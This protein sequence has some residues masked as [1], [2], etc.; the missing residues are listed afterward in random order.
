M[1][2][3]LLLALVPL[4]LLQAAPAAAS[5]NNQVPEPSD[6]A[7]F[8]LGLLGVIIGRHGFRRSRKDGDGK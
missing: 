6:L 8:S 1:A 4:L 3:F 2:R 7:L 5:W